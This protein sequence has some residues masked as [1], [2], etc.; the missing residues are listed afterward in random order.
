M[1]RLLHASG[2]HPIPTPYDPNVDESESGSVG[3][4]LLRRFIW[5]LF[6]NV[7]LKLLLHLHTR[8]I[9]LSSVLL[10]MHVL[11]IE[12]YQDAIFEDERDESNTQIEKEAATLEKAIVVRYGPEQPVQQTMTYT[13]KG[14]FA[15]I[16]IRVIKW[17]TQFFPKID[18]LAK[19]KGM[20]EVVAR[21][22]PVEEHCQLVLNTAWEVISSTMANF[23]DWMHFHTVVRLR[24]V[25]SF[26]DL[27]KT[28][29]QFML[30]AETEQVDE[31]LQQRSMLMYKLYELEVQKLVDEHLENFKLDVP[32]VNHDYLSIRFLNKE[33]KEI[34][35]QHRDQRVL[36][37]LRIAAPE[38]SFAGDVAK[39]AIPQLS[40]SDVV[41][42]QSSWGHE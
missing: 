8:I 7:C 5:I 2:S 9:L 14:I 1:H 35:R 42:S 21:P 30:L 34:T 32:S 24:D 29:D 33:L 19:D 18:P 41:T 37:G 38:A 6:S 4:L 36:A 10:A 3:I 11:L 25:S 15:P 28:E 23:D 16:Q 39:L 27:T 40:L 22:N 13:G 12:E 26:E 20:L 31:L 17:A